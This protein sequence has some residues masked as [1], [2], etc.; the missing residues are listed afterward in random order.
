MNVR[1]GRACPTEDRFP[2]FDR[3]VRFLHPKRERKDDI[4]WFS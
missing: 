4:N 3:I 1:R 2:D